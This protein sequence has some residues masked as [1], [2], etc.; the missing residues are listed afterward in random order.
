M[1]AEVETTTV[2]GD[3][4][5]ALRLR[6]EDQR[7]SDVEVAAASV[8][9]VALLGTAGEGPQP[10]PE[11]AWRRAGLWESSTAR[12]VRSPAELHRTEAR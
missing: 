9:V 6:V 5:A 11:P 1:S 8:A 2:V 10:T 4:A 12:R 7:V 3:T